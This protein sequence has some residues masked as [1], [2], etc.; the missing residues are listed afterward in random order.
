MDLFSGSM[1]IGVAFT[2]LGALIYSVVKYYQTGKYECDLG[3]HKFKDT[4]G[5]PLPYTFCSRRGCDVS[6]VSRWA[7]SRIAVQLHNAIPE[8][9]RF[10]PVELNS[11]GT[12]KRELK[13]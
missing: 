6:A 10:P 4:P 2:A 12:V 13:T 8:D 3:R 11:D 9:R 5:V 7:D 1:V